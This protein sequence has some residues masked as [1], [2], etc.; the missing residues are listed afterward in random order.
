MNRTLLL[1]IF[2]YCRW[3]SRRFLRFTR[4]YHSERWPTPKN[5]RK[6]RVL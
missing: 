5:K 1:F 4:F 3:S 2:V 6:K